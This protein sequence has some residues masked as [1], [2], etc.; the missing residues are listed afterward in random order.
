MWLRVYGPTVVEVAFRPIKR[1][2]WR[3]WHVGLMGPRVQVGSGRFQAF[4]GRL[5][6]RTP[7]ADDRQRD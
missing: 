1:D 3:F 4:S 6:Y 5:G 7:R 2:F